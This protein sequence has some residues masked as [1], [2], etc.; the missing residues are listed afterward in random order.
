MKYIKIFFLL[1]TTTQLF[2]ARE[3]GNGGNVY[4]CNDGSVHLVDTYEIQFIAGLKDK[5]TFDLTMNY[6]E[7]NDRV[8]SRLQAISERVDRD[9]WHEQF[10]I[11]GALE[12]TVGYSRNM[13]ADLKD[14]PIPD[15][16]IVT[17]MFYYKNPSRVEYNEALWS[18]FKKNEFYYLGILL[19]EAVF[20][21]LREISGITDS[22]Y[23]ARRIVALLMAN[24]Y[25]PEILEFLVRFYI[26]KDPWSKSMFVFPEL[27]QAERDEK[28]MV[29]YKGRCTDKL[30]WWCDRPKEVEFFF[31]PSNTL[32]KFYIKKYSFVLYSLY[33]E[34]LTNKLSIGLRYPTGEAQRKCY[35]TIFSKKRHFSKCLR[36]AERQKDYGWNDVSVF[37][38]TL[39][40]LGFENDYSKLTFNATFVE[41]PNSVKNFLEYE[42]IK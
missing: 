20:K 38:Y 40:E 22:S 31:K 39:Q 23:I 28:I 8:V 33:P 32:S 19:H 36:K 3:V 6:S 15:G 11:F 4:V 1:L 18:K 10:A 5:L 14:V 25:Y 26:H 37:K 12:P 27:Q 42:F 7:I 21:L 9:I 29:R 16:C 24:E 30:A 17:N 35:E 34:Q 13:T 2:A 41:Y